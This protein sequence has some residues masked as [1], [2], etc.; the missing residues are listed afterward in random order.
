MDDMMKSTVVPQ[1]SR[2]ISELKGKKSDGKPTLFKMTAP[3]LDQGRSNTP[4]AHTE[5][6][7][8]TLKV[9]ASGGENGLH[10]HPNEDHTFIVMQGKARYY[11]PDGVIGDR[12]PFEGIM[13][14]AGA[15]YWFEAISSEPLVLLRIG[16]RTGAHDPGGR[17]NI[18]GEAMPG[19]SPENKQV[20]VKVR[21]GAFFGA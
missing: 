11:G 8:V 14:P 13:L 7:W 6:M 5:N 4:L 16:S 17:L 21:E 15:Y 20:P 9:Y 10:T 3:L 18:R 19:D 1:A 12:G 2:K